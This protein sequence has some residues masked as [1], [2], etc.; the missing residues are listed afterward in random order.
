MPLAAPAR[1]W[2]NRPAGRGGGPSPS[3]RSGGVGTAAGLARLAP[4]GQ[5]PC[6]P[7]TRRLLA[8]LLPCARRHGAGALCS[9]TCLWRPFPCVHHGGD[10]VWF[11]WGTCPTIDYTLIIANNGYTN[12]DTDNFA[13]KKVG[14][15]V[16]FFT[17]CGYSQ[18]VIGR[19]KNCEILA[20]APGGRG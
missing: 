14:K 15:S 7:A 5:R 8:S 20:P 1:V 13:S 12:G 17:Q 19:R 2:W 10:A 4:L 16:N 18:K 3:G 6:R 11:R 9:H